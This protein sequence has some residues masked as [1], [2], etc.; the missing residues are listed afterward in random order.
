MNYNVY[1]I[2]CLPCSAC[3]ENSNCPDI[4][5]GCAY[6][7]VERSLAPKLGLI[8]VTD[9]KPLKILTAA[10]LNFD[11]FNIYSTK[12]SHNTSVLNAY[13]T[14]LETCF[15]PRTYTR[16]DTGL[17]SHRKGRK[18]FNPRTY[19]RC[20]PDILRSGNQLSK[21]QS[22]HLHEVRLIRPCTACGTST[23][24]NPRTYTRCDLL[25]RTPARPD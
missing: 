17:L 23:G 21:F 24:F 10:H 2:G 20:D 25:P 7:Q 18:S 22:A 5:K 13:I 9:E 19:T 4:N 11:N 6:T 1:F 3:R 16:C 15:N 14:C 8:L 12:E